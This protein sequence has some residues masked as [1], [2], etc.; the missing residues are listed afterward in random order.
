[1]KNQSLPMMM[2]VALQCLIFLVWGQPD[3]GPFNPPLVHLHDNAV[4]D[5]ED[6]EEWDNWMPH[7]PDVAPAADQ[8]NEPQQELMPDLNMVPFF[9]LQELL[10]GIDQIA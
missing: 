1:M 8:P 2:M 4:E 3:P 9:E 7:E 5:D 6:Q 10:D